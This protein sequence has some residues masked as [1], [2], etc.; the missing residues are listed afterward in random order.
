MKNRLEL[1][2]SYDVETLTPE[3]RSRL[4]KMSKL[5]SAYGQRVQYSV[6][7]LQVTP[8][9]FQKFVQRATQL[10]DVNSDSVRVYVLNGKRSDYLQVYGR[11]GWVDFDAPLIL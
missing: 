9:L 1:L 3:G 4:R 7:E 11:D 8:A 2:V 10:I 5:C 6:F